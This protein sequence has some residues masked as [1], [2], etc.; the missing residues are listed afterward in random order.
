M[1][2][3]T[4]AQRD[5]IVTWLERVDNF[6]RVTAPSRG[7]SSASSRRGGGS[8]APDASAD[9]LKATAAFH[10]LATFV[11]V[12]APAS[13]WNSEVAYQRLADYLLQYR[14]AVTR[15]TSP[16][17]ALTPT[18]KQAGL[19]SVADKLETLCRH[20]GRLQSLHAAAVAQGLP[21]ETTAAGTAAAEPRKLVPRA[22]VP[23]TAATLWMDGDEKLEK[24]LDTGVDS[25]NVR[26]K[27]KAS[28]GGL[29]VLESDEDEVDDELPVTPVVDA[30]RKAPSS[31]AKKK[32][33]R[34]SDGEAMWL[35]RKARRV[36]RSAEAVESSVQGTRSSAS[37]HSQDELRSAI[38][39]VI[40][41]R[42]QLVDSRAAA[43]LSRQALEREQQGV[44]EEEQAVASDEDL[45]AE[46]EDHEV[47]GGSRSSRDIGDG[48]SGF[49]PVLGPLL[50][51]GDTQ[52]MERKRVFLRAKQLAFQQLKWQQEEELQKRELK[53]LRREMQ[54]RETLAQRELQVRRLRVR[55]ELMHPMIV[56]GASTAQIAERLQLL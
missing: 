36:E 39:Q 35:Q 20:F 52:R 15:A 9:R 50:S 29:V 32:T 34:S 11:N 44:E 46:F 21:S 53:L 16:Q 31:S 7:A 30:G 41:Q 3:A 6:A 47:V 55:A 49:L 54:A 27:Q 24:E 48:A 37:S 14:A 13:A 51:G 45:P 12:A 38:A 5:A 17:F 28:A 19:R 2:Q 22:P 1:S 4:D 8:P 23:S 43:A 10:E 33:A 26:Q 42:Q 56:A 25:S 18:D 40:S